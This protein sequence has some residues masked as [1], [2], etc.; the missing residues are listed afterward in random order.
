MSSQ[1]QLRESSI[2]NVK[3]VSNYIERVDEMIERKRSFFNEN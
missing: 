3:D 1:F 2:E